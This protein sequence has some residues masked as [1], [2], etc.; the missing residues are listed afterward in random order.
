V[1]LRRSAKA[2]ERHTIARANNTNISLLLMRLRYLTER[3]MT[4]TARTTNTAKN[5]TM[6]TIMLIKAKSGPTLIIRPPTT[7]R[8]TMEM[9]SS[10]MIIPSMNSV[11]VR[12]SRPRSMSAFMA[13]AEQL[14]ARMAERKTASSSGQPK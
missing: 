8:K 6:P 11:S 9:N 2:A 7:V 14:M 12:S 10:M 4:R 3:G 5:A 13:T 1:A